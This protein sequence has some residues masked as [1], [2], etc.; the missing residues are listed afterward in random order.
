VET[1]KLLPSTRFQYC[2]TSSR[3]NLE[4]ISE[5]QFCN[6]AGCDQVALR[7][8][9]YHDKLRVPIESVKVDSVGVKVRYNDV[10]CVNKFEPSYILSGGSY[11]E[12]AV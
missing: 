11:L 5:L 4:G 8:M 3:Q 2:V 6:R 10:S 9:H 7:V 1:S 12:V